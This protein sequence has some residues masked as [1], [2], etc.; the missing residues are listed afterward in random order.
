MSNDFQ[1]RALLDEIDAIE[2]EIRRASL[3]SKK[4]LDSTLKYVGGFAVAGILLFD[5]LLVFGS[6]AFGS[7]LA[8]MI[9]VL[10]RH[11]T[12]ALEQRRDQLIEAGSLVPP[13]LDDS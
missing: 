13:R 7:A 3:R 2:A 12:K 1:K 10:R 8:L 4:A 11:R 6:V 9:A 5:G